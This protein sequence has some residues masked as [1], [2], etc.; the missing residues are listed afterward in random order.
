M[1][2]SLSQTDT[3]SFYCHENE[4]KLYM[5]KLHTSDSNNII[6]GYTNTENKLKLWNYFILTDS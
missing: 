2:I 1:L 4:L 3:G 6:K 5:V